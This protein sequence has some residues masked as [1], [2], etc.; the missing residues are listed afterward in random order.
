MSVASFWIRGSKTAVFGILPTA[1]H[2]PASRRGLDES[3]DGAGMVDM[4]FPA[5]EAFLYVC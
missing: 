2:A 3:H 4:G 5:T 1:S